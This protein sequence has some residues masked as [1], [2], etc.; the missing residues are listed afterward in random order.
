MGCFYKC[1]FRLYSDE[2]Y[3]E[4]V[5]E[6]D[7]KIPVAAFDG[8]IPPGVN[9]TSSNYDYFARFLTNNSE[10]LFVG[11]LTW[12]GYQGVNP[13]L[14]MPLAQSGNYNSEDANNKYPEIEFPKGLKLRRRGV[15][16]DSL[17]TGEYFISSDGNELWWGNADFLW[18]KHVNLFNGCN[19]LVCTSMAN[20]LLGGDYAIF[21][22]SA[23]GPPWR[24]ILY[25]NSYSDQAFIDVLNQYTK[26]IFSAEPYLEIPESAPGG[27]GDGTF[28]FESTPIDFQGLPSIGAFDTGMIDLYVP[29]A[30]QLAALSNYLWAGAFDPNNFK[31]IL[32]NP[33]DAIIGLSIVPVSSSEIGTKPSTLSVGNISTGL[34]MSK[35]SR[36]YVSVD[37]GSIS[38]LPKYGAYL[39]FAPHS[40]LQLFLPYIGY[41]NIS[42]D[43]CMNGSISVKYT[44]DI[45]SG[46]CVAQVKCNDH[47]LYEYSGQCSCSCPV[48]A[49]QYQNISLTALKVAGSVGSAV[50]GGAAGIATGLENAS[51]AIISSAKPEISR[52]GGFGGSSGLMG[53]Q[54]PYLILT[55]PRMCRPGEQNAM[56][57]Y[58]AFV[59]KTVSDLSGYIQVDTVHLAGVP[60]TE[61]EQS[62]IIDLLKSGVFV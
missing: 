15:L 10:L 43:D 32:A 24:S 13:S 5:F 19:S 56:I 36:Q 62:E 20:G 53:H 23:A 18:G 22:V 2:N 58:P 54:V 29:S 28:N 51:N 38:V 55:I 40:K 46:T 60:A 42:P 34:S 59:T 26:P 1:K 48:T 3:T 52:S 9:A 7:I 47:V 30:G 49:G 16:G 50:L 11:G 6:Q 4:Q 25:G 8:T 17:V 39:D 61:E 27:L 45:L 37:C 31:K 14:Y 44:V 33:M 41:V 21:K 57:G 35:A 12:G